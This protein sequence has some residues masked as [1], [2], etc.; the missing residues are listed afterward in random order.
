M[1]VGD[2]E[3][4]KTFGFTGIPK[5]L[6]SKCKCGQLALTQSYCAAGVCSL[7]QKLEFQL[8]FIFLRIKRV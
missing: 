2:Y 7:D 4:K 3:P 1:L 8:R 5:T 6:T